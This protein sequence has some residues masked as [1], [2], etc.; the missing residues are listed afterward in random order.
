MFN[1]I[2]QSLVNFSFFV[3]FTISVV[4]IP[5][6]TFAAEKPVQNKQQIATLTVNINKASAEELSDVM[7]GVGL[8]KAI[9]IVEYRTKIGFF[10]KVEDLLEVKGIGP[11]T[12]E[13]NRHKLQI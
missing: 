3:L 5:G 2:V 10:K 4:L 7:T 12:L 11:A 1:K 8:K 13:K 9:A 6:S